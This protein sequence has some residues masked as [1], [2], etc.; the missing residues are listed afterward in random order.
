VFI[1][2]YAIIIVGFAFVGSQ[3]LSFDAAFTDPAAPLKMDPYISNYGE[4]KTMIFNVYAMATYDYFP[5]HQLLAVQN[6][7]PN[8]IY[9]IVFVFFNMFL[10]ASIPGSLIYNKFRETRSK[11]IL[12]DEIKQQHSLI[13]GFVSLAQEEN[14]LSIE[15]L[16]KFLF[17]FYRKKIRYVEY[18]T[19]IC[20]KLDANNNQTI[21][22]LPPRSKSTSSCS[23][24]K[25]CS[26]TPSCSRPPS[27]TSR[28]GS[29]SGLQS[30][31]PSN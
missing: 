24:P 20:L 29:T 21:V 11:Y 25:S 17:S 2:Y 19:E 9:F 4:L 27:T 1:I 31:T 6:Y 7:Q 10:F 26:T 5:D 18:I 22:S 14:N 15:E 28:F 13:L 30:T 23:S 16:I 3:A 8:Y 12:V